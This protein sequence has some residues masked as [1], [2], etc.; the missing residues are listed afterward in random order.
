MC[1]SEKK[2]R[3]EKLYVYAYSTAVR[4]TKMSMSELKAG[5]RHLYVA[6]GT[7]WM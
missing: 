2:K 6:K 1:T 5:M 4:P 7:L 3:K